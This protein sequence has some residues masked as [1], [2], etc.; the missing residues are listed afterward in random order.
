MKSH[1]TNSGQV[2]WRYRTEGA[3]LATCGEDKIMLGAKY[4]HTGN[5]HDIYTLLYV[6]TQPVRL[7]FVYSRSLCPFG[8]IQTEWQK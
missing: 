2:V 3:K 6:S 7:L 8:D 5:D 4:R 1:L